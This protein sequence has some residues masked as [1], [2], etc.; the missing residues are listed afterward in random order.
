VRVSAGRTFTKAVDPGRAKATPSAKLA[1][2]TGIPWVTGPGAPGIGSS[3]LVASATIS[4]SRSG[5]L[6]WLKMIT[7]SAPVCSA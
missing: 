3:M 5:V 2:T 6:P 7:A 1:P 4:A